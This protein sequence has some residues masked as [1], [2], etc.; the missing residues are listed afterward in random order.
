MNNLSNRVI[1]LPLSFFVE[2]YLNINRIM[3]CDVGDARYTTTAY[4]LLFDFIIECIWPDHG[5]WEIINSHAAGTYVL[6]NTGRGLSTETCEVDIV[7]LPG[8]VGLGSDNDTNCAVIHNLYLD[9]RLM[10]DVIC[11]S[12]SHWRGNGMP[13]GGLTF[14]DSVCHVPDV[15]NVYLYE[16]ING[17]GT[18]LYNYTP[19]RMFPSAEFIF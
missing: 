1:I 17:C 15:R 6:L 12:M 7:F 9:V 10:R 16:T 19:P 14:P 18:V 13:Y 5:G 8:N 4:T 3:E 2:K 11:I